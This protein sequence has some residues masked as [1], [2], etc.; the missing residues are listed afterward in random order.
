VPEKQAAPGFR[1]VFGK[2]ITRQAQMGGK[3][4]IATLTLSIYHYQSNVL[5]ILQKEI[6][7]LNSKVYQ[8]KFPKFNIKIE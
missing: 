4:V 3:S 2:S 7:A 8:I 5:S 6:R 1:K